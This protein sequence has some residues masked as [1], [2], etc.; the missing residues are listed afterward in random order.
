MSSSV[1]FFD[2]VC[3]LCNSTVKWIISHDKKRIFKYSSL[4]SNYAKV[5]IID[6]SLIKLDSIILKIDNRFYKKS[7]AVLMILSKLGFPYN[8]SAVA[9]A[10]P[11][12]ISDFFY[13]IVAKYRYRWF[14]RRESCMLPSE[15][16]KSLFLE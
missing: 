5:N 15:D 13:D 1:V 9:L 12:F 4:Q 2:G 11:S 14:G 8:M 10:I 16:I 6:P 3:N 7:R